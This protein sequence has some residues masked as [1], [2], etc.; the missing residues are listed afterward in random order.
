MS[1]GTNNLTSPLNDSEQAMG[2]GASKLMELHQEEIP[3]RVVLILKM[4]LG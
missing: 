1:G 2:G 3:C 4:Q